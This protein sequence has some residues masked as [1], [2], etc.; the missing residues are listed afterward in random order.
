MMITHV[1]V[2]VHNLYPILHV[3]LYLQRKKTERCV[4]AISFLNVIVSNSFGI[5]SVKGFKYVP[6]LPAKI[7]TFN[8]NVLN[9]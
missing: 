1:P 8:L 4:G 2:N 5:I 9:I 6:R 7:I 3:L